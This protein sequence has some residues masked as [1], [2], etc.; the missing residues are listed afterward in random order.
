MSNHNLTEEYIDCKSIV[1]HRDSALV[2]IQNFHNSIKA[3]IDEMAVIDAD[4]PRRA[5]FETIYGKMTDDFTRQDFDDYLAK[6]Q[7]LKTHLENEGWV[8]V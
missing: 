5:A 8:D 1:G 4:S 6:I 3:I 7:T 2:E